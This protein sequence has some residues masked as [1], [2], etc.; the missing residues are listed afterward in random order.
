MCVGETV[1]VIISTTSTLQSHE[2]KHYLLL[3]GNEITK[4]KGIFK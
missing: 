1:F 3:G 2:D 4:K